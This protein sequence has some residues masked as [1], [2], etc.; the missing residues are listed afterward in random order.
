MKSIWFC[1]DLFVVAVAVVVVSFS[2]GERA[3]LFTTPSPLILA[4]FL[5][6][7]FLLFFFSGVFLSLFVHFLGGGVFSRAIENTDLNELKRWCQLNLEN[8]ISALETSS[9]NSSNNNNDCIYVP[10]IYIYVYIIS[11][12][13]LVYVYMCYVYSYV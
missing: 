6:N 13:Y 7:F 2:G 9:F 10:R 4:L 12:I 1:F 5:V 11:Y 3:P 8:P